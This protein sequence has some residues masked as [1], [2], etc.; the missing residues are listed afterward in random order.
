MLLLSQTGAGEEAAADSFALT[1]AWSQ[2]VNTDRSMLAIEPRSVK[3]N[4][5]GNADGERP[6]NSLAALPALQNSK[7]SALY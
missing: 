1:R 5:T 3:D 6:Q 2:P 4:Q 7:A